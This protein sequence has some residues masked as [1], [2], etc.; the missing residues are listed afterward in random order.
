MVNILCKFIKAECTGNWALHLQST[1]GMLPYLAASGN[2]HYVKSLRLYLQY[3]VDLR[4]KRKDVYDK[5]QEGFHVIRR[6]ERKWAGLSTDLAIEQALMHTLKTTGGL[7]RGR[8]M[9]EKQKSIWLLSMPTC[10]DLTI[11]C[12]SSLA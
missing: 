12:R 4:E 7:T 10:A 1:S 11:Q 5:F 6:S 3:M 8:G 2:H 9:T